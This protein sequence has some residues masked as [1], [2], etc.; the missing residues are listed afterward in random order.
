M[1]QQKLIYLVNFSRFLMVTQNRRV[2]FSGNYKPLTANYILRFQQTREY[3][4]CICKS[5][6]FNTIKKLHLRNLLGK[7]INLIFTN[8]EQRL[9]CPIWSN[10]KD[11][12]KEGTQTGPNLIMAVRTSLHLFLKAI[13]EHDEL[14]GNANQTQSTWDCLR[15]RDTHWWETCHC[16]SPS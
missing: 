1:L 10:S 7:S 16:H 3:W 14:R 8:T 4:A 13:K 12:V 2:R 5:H 15:H 11:V 9:C 6:L